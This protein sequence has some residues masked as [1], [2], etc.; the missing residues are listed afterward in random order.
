MDQSAK[1]HWAPEK[2]KGQPED[3]EPP[4]KDAYCYPHNRHQSANPHPSASGKPKG[5]PEDIDPPIKDAYR[6]PHNRHQSTTPHPKEPGEGPG[7][8]GAGPGGQGAGRPGDPGTGGQG[9]GGPEGLGAGDPG[10]QGPR[11]GPEGQGPGAG[12]QGSDGSSPQ[13]TAPPEQKQPT[14]WTPN[15]KLATGVGA[16]TPLAV[17]ITYIAQLAG[18]E[19]PQEVALAIG[20]LIIGIVGY[21]TPPLPPR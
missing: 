7:G 9:A 18:L 2:P 4:I 14:N 13:N 11:V 10:V 20:G 16:G 19:L 21:F 1:P 12:G 15:P 17:I 3:I 6:Y 8:P 5:Q